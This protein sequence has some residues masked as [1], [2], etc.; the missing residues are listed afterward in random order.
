MPGMFRR[1]A[2]RAGKVGSSFGATRSAHG[3]F[4]AIG[5]MGRK[6]TGGMSPAQLARSGKI[7]SAAV[8]GG[9]L[10]INA[11]GSRRGRGVDK[12]GRGRP[13]GMYGY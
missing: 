8:A 11:I 13:T 12:S 1:G 9:V 2:S 4:A 7:R 5:A 6:S 3:T 10:G